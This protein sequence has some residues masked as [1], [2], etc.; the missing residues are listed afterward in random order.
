RIMEERGQLVRCD[1]GQKYQLTAAGVR[2]HWQ[3][4]TR[5]ALVASPPNPTGTVLPPQ[6]LAELAAAVREQDG[7]LWVDEIYQGLNYTSPEHTVLS[8]ADDAVVLNSI[9]KF[10]GMTGWR[11]GWAVVPEHWVPVLDTLAQNLFL[12]PPTPAQYA[13]LAAF[14][15][16]SMAILEARRQELAQRREYLLQALPELGFRLPVAPDGAFYIYADASAFTQDSLNWCARELEETGVA[17][18]PGVA[19]GAHEAGSHVRFAFT[20]SVTRL[21]E[22]VQ[23]LRDWTLLAILRD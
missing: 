7:E 3:P 6:E 16:D 4:G 13:A 18:T 5:A 14:E 22:S 10:F 9:S 23:Q 17:I 19:F 11:L 8:V 21:Q 12:A 20:T 2:Q 1:A 15:P